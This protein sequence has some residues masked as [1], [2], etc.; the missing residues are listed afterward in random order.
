MIAKLMY[1]FQC[2]VFQQLLVISVSFLENCIQFFSPF[3]DWITVDSLVFHFYM[4]LYILDMTPLFHDSLAKTCSHSTISFDVCCAEVL[5]FQPIPFASTRD[6]FLSCQN[7]SRK[8]LPEL[9]SWRT[10]PTS[11]SCTFKASGLTLRS[12]IH[13]YLNLAQDAIER[14]FRIALGSVVFYFIE[15]PIGPKNYVCSTSIRWNIL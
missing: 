12:L 5:S 14:S 1:W 8:S 9:V 10:L 2:V 3:A 7:L 13:F 11:S 15:V 6:D 4:H